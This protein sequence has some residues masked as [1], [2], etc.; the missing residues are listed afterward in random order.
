MLGRTLKSEAGVIW[1]PD[2]NGFRVTAVVM[3][4]RHPEFAK[5]ANRVVKL[6][7]GLVGSVKRNR[8]PAKTTDLVW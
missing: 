4:P 5:L 8:E 2:E 6:K 7:R 3:I 1:L